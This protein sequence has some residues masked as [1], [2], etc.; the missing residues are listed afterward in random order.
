MFSLDN[1]M[2]ELYIERTFVMYLQADQ[3]VVS[4]KINIERGTFILSGK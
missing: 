1:R 4:V 2:I 3:K